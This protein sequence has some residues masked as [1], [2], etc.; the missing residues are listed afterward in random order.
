MAKPP[1]DTNPEKFIIGRGWYANLRTA[2]PVDDDQEFRIDVAPMPITTIAI[3]NAVFIM[4][5]GGFY[6][7]CST[8]GNASK[9]L[10]ALAT[11]GIG[12]TTCVSFTAV[13]Y[14]SFNNARRRGPWLIVNKLTKKIA[15]PREGVQFD[16]TEV[17]HLQYITTKR[18]DWGGV[19]NNDQLSE[20]NL[21][22]CTDGET[23]RWPILRSISSVMAFEYIIAPLLDCTDMP[24]VR[25]VDELLGWKITETELHK[26]RQ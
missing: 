12:A 15:L 2:V 8:Y 6:W 19:L 20:L 3:L 1:H 14:C 21:I 23:K 26:I 7:A 16:V 10:I 18:L 5:F 9:L 24:V 25:I 13:T 11:I 17:V 4:F 22:T